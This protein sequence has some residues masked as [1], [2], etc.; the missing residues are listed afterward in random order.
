MTVVR[1]IISLTLAASASGAAGTLSGGIVKV[2]GDAFAAAAMPDPDQAQDQP[3]WLWRFHEGVFSSGANARADAVL[4]KEDLKG[5]RKLISE[6]DILALT[7][8]KDATVAT[9][10]VDGLIRTLWLRS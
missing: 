9:V 10:N 5:R 8:N 6:S 7:M 3:G 4:L 1:T 2:D